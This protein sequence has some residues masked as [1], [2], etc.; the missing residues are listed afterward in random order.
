MLFRGLLCATVFLVVGCARHARVVDVPTEAAPKGDWR[1]M[2]RGDTLD[3]WVQRGGGAS[4]RVEGGEIIGETRPNQPNSFLC[5]LAEYRDF[6]L[7]LDFLV[8]SRLNSGVQVRSEYRD[9]GAKQRVFGYQVEIDPSARHWTGGIYDEGRRGW[10]R[11][12][13]SDSEAAKAFVQGQW[14][15]MKVRCEGDHI[16]TWINEIPCADLRDAMTKEGL[17]G[18]QVHG[19]GDRADPLRVRWR[20]IRLRELVAQ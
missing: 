17:I 1:P 9:E 8:D 20:N 14:N 12:L 18:L 10:L 15:R 16:Q 13:A 6:E 11:P 3:G 2:I 19:V 7:E 4:F 5:T